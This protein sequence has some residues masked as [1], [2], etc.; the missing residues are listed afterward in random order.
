[1]PL[2]TRQFAQASELDQF[3]IF[4]MVSSDYYLQEDSDRW[5]YCTAYCM[6]GEL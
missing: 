4:A 2:K 3:F 1:M 6:G 5:D